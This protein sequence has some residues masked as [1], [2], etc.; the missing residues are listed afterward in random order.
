MISRIE[1]KLLHY[2]GKAISIYDLI[3]KD[4]RLL[5]CL[6]GGKDSFTMVRLLQLLQI[7]ARGKFKL[8]VLAIDKGLIGWNKTEIESWLKNSGLDH[9]ILDSNI[10]EVVAAK[11]RK[12]YSPCILC[13]RLRR[14]YIYSFAKKHGFNKIALGH[15]REDLI[16]SLLMSMFYNGNISSMPPKLLTDDKKLIVIRP[17]V[18]CQERDVAAYAK[19]QRFPLAPDGICPIKEKNSRSLVAQLIHSLAKDNNKIPS[20]ILRAISQVKP[21]HLM[22]SKLWD[23]INLKISPSSLDSADSC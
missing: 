8:H 15:H 10:A 11:E 21:S 7:R 17:L 22:D 5:L 1:K 4:D 18:Y 12:N 2:T 13:S 6:S 9:T 3:Q 23:F 14:G 16:V 20:N 19:E